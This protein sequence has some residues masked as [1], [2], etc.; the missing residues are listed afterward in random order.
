MY[1]RKLS[2]TLC[3]KTRRLHLCLAGHL[4]SSADKQT[5]RLGKSLAGLYPVWVRL[6][7]SSHAQQGSVLTAAP[8]TW[9][10]KHIVPVGRSR[11]TN[12]C[13][14]EGNQTPSNANLKHHY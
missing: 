12:G 6:L 11:S 3:L 4:K 5:D 2:Q 1:G 7:L 14:T 13:C 9:V 10:R 8:T